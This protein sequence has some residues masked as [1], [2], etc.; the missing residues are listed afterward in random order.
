[1]AFEGLYKDIDFMAPNKMRLQKRQLGLQEIGQAMGQYN[2]EQDR[3]LRRRQLELEAQEEEVF[4]LQ[5]TAEQSLYNKSK[6][7]PYDESAIRA[8]SQLKGQ[9]MA[10]GEYGGLVP[11]QT[12]AQRAGIVADQPP[13]TRDLPPGV[14]GIV[15][16][17]SG[18]PISA[19][20][21]GGG[22]SPPL[23]P[24]PSLMKADQFAAARAP[25][26]RG[27]LAGTPRGEIMEAQAGLDVQKEGIREE[28]AAKNLMKY[29]GEQLQSSLFAS[30]MVEATE[31]M[32]ALGEGS[33]EGRTGFLGGV[34]RVLTALPFGDT[35]TGFGDALVKLG[36]TE[37]QQ[38]Y[39]NA[40]NHWV[41]ANLRDESGAAISIE[42]AAKEVAKYFPTP[43]DSP[44]VVAD[45]K[46]LRE[47]AE[48]GMIGKSAGAYQQQYGKKAQALAAQRPKSG[49]TSYKDY[50]K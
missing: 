8:Y 13:P 39:L 38:R 44:A 35:G 47:K 20:P 46:R 2:A 9:Q 30:R 12:L 27:V 32:D 29:S 22:I 16:G 36:A 26:V 7:L 17:L 33:E 11:M 6:G 50:F 48:K 10:T 31:I 3:E 40:A 42:E 1:M 49:A 5:K 37:E 18:A 41:T 28:R 14:E 34:S 43:L 25:Q 23:P 19:A 45:K 15:P 4:N 24:P 21:S